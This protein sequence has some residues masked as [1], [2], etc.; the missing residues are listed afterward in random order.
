MDIFLEGDYTIETAE[1]LHRQLQQAMQAKQA[2][3]LSFAGVGYADLAFFQII[4]AAL[5]S[6]SRRKTTLT[7]RPDLPPHLARKASL[8]GLGHIAPS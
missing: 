4:H 5:H 7:L 3:T 8:C 1:T 2:V 6:F